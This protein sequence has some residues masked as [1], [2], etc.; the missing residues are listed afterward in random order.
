MLTLLGWVGSSFF[1]RPLLNQSER[2]IYRI[3]LIGLLYT[4]TR[5]RQGKTYTAHNRSGQERLL[6]IEHPVRPGF[7]LVDTTKPAQTARDVYRFELPVPA[8]K[9]KSLAVTEEQISQ[10]AIQLSNSVCSI[11]GSI[12]PP[13]PITGCGCWVRKNH[14]ER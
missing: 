4:S 1:I 3:P 7:T 6:L 11:R 14:M 5:L 13:P 9:S 8:G 2:L 10:Q 12:D